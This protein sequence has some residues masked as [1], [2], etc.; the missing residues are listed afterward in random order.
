MSRF[1]N[2]GT[3]ADRIVC[4][5]GSAAPTTSGPITIAALVRPDNSAGTGWML[6]WDDGSFEKWGQLVSG[7]QFF[8]DNDFNGGPTYTAGRW[9][10][11]IS[12]KANGSVAPRWHVYDFTA[13][14]WTHVNGGGAIANQSGTPVNAIIGGQ[15]FGGASTTW[16]GAIA[17]GGIWG[18]LLGSD[19]TIESI[20][21]HSAANMLAAGP[22]WMVLLNQSSVATAVTDVSGHGGNQTSISGTSVDADDPPGFD[23]SLTSSVTKT[24]DLRWSISQ[25]VI[26][27]P[28]L[29]WS[30]AQSVTK[31]LDLRW[32]IS[33]SVTSTVDL[34]WQILQT[35]TKNLEL[36][37]SVAQ[38]LVKQADFRWSIS[39]VVA[40]QADVRWQIEGQV[41]A[42]AALQWSIDGPTPSAPKNA[43]IANRHANTLVINRRAGIDFTAERG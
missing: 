10:W 27:T 7:G 33:E 15:S 14:A 20:F 42:T 22:A 13:N 35:I 37:W 1:F 39:Q 4:S 17:V 11:V 23:Y 29:R 41:K 3:A 25:P 34:R 43:F 26:A 8:I 31:N 12:E 2:G 32:A 36:Q 40:Y 19:A 21:T 18:S 5:P 24:V 30:I 16:R 6:D 9:Y 28:D 38:Q